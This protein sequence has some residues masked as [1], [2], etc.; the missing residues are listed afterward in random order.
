MRRLV[1]FAAALT[2]A[3]SVSAAALDS[4]VD[5]LG[6]AGVDSLAA[7]GALVVQ[8]RGNSSR[9]AAVHWRTIEAL[10]AAS[11]SCRTLAA[12]A[13]DGPVTAADLGLSVCRSLPPGL[14]TPRLQA[15]ASAVA[16]EGEERWALVSSKASLAEPPGVPNFY[17]TA[18]GKDF[19]VRHRADRI[20]DPLP[21]TKAYFDEI[22]AG[23]RPIFDATEHLNVVLTAR[24]VTDLESRV[25]A[26]ASR[27]SLSEELRVLIRRYLQDERRRRGLF[28]ARERRKALF[29]D[30]MTR[31]D[32][33]ALSALAEKFSTPG[34]VS[35]LE[36]SVSAVPAPSGLPRLRSAGIHLREPVRLNQYELGDDAVVSGAYWLD[37]LPENE[38]VEIEET[39][40]LE[41][42]SGYSGTQ[43]R[44]VK[45]SNGGPFTFE[46]ILSLAD[47]NSSTFIWRVSAASGS[48]IAERVEVPVTTDFELSLK[49][50]ADILQSLQ[51][52]DPAT[53]EASAMT[54]EDA[55]TGASKV[56]PQY[57]A[58]LSRI[59]SERSRAGEDKIKLVKLEELM[60]SARTDAS[61]DQCRY[62]TNRVD[63]ALKTLRT[64][65]AGCD[66]FLPPL[67]AS[68]SLIVRRAGD[69]AWFMKTSSEARSRR[70]NCDFEGAARRWTEA[71]SVL[72]ANPPARC[73]AVATEAKAAETELSSVIRAQAWSDS[74]TKSLE[75]AELEVIP[76]KRLAQSAPIIARLTTV[77][78]TDCRSA[79]LKRT[80]QLSDKAGLDE[81][82]PQRG[83]AEK[84]LPA[85][86]SLPLLVA[87]IRLGRAR[88]LDKSDAATA[89]A[90]EPPAPE[91]KAPEVLMPTASP[92]LPAPGE[93]PASPAK[94]AVK[95]RRKKA[96][97]KSGRSR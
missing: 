3:S 95:I 46:R 13:A 24:G 39:T 89:P 45:R 72:D 70:R 92:V 33:D 21:L 61:P 73:G 14:M 10:A 29:N 88:A 22:L 7:R 77:G 23:I 48:V 57:K 8:V 42:P 12:A 15:L 80:T 79:M 6:Q 9:L 83:E 66:R 18:W 75:K 44:S 36:S 56:K 97:G 35:L 51:A 71:L 64:L 58:L 62:D 30:K 20:D 40:W 81:A 94:P 69:Q 49:R 76:A 82:G 60:A 2:C 74:L 93:P 52:C 55:V 31:A 37:G 53:A 43:T 27:G 87:E 38:S 1:V 32:L 4:F 19:A 17:E 96:A 78:D 16:A 26:D 54:L 5:K 68:R 90:A 34:L 67:I 47:T 59:K 86:N 41:S 11:K 85:D 28:V 65:P 63:T 84:L 25:T 91:E 50:E